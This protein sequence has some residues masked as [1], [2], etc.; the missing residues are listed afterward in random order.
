M[1]SCAGSTWLANVDPTNLL[2]L[3]NSSPCLG[4]PPRF[5]FPFRQ[6]LLNIPFQFLPVA[7]NSTVPHS[8]MLAW[9][10]P[11]IIPP[12][13][14][15]HSSFSR[16]QRFSTS[17]MIFH[18]YLPP[19]N[20]LPISPEVHISFLLQLQKIRIPL[21]PLPLTTVGKVTSPHCHW[22]GRRCGNT[23]C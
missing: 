17:R 11:N 10:H 18:I 23:P 1:K 20:I 15:S 13:L 5:P 7:P 4:W 3:R 8:S 9:L 21:L 2:H 12:L 16:C 19:G 14:N 6:L 22:S